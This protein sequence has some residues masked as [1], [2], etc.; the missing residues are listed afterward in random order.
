[1]T[2]TTYHKSKKRNAGKILTALVCCSV[3]GGIIGAGSAAVYGGFLKSAESPDG[4]TDITAPAQTVEILEGQREVTAVNVS[5]V[6]TSSKMPAS[7]IY[8]ANVNSTVGIT[9]SVTTNYFGYATTAAASGSGFIITENGYIITNYHVVEDADEIRV[10]AYDD[11]VYAAELVGYDESNDIA[12]LKIDAEGLT[13]VVLGDSDLMNVGDGVIAI[14]NPLGEL[15]FS[16]TQGVV[17][18]LDRE[19]T[20]NNISMD[21]IQTDCAINS[22]N[23]GGALFNEYGEVI[24]ITNAKYSSSGTSGASIDNVGFAIPI[25]SVIETV[26]SIIENGYI[27]RPYIG[28]SAYELGSRYQITGIVVSSVEEGS[29]AEEAGLQENDVITKVD[30]TDVSGVSSFKNII[31]GHDE[32]DRILLTVYRNGRYIE[33]EV[34]VGLHKQTALP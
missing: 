33:T 21:L 28:I 34:E 16:L 20:I 7:E 32:G 13:P 3:M 17:S 30:D 9:T 8:A 11:T 18:A 24:G 1:M 12:V 10:T 22:G 31:S 5:Y 6:D 4:G 29:P 23:S 19:I 14:G 25:N 2:E 27:V 26:Q 15:T